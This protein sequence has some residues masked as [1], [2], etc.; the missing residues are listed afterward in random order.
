L[1]FE[2]DGIE[3]RDSL[4][5]KCLWLRASCDNYTENKS[6]IEIDHIVPEGFDYKRH[7]Q[8]PARIEWAIKNWWLTFTKV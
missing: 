2:D 5:G 1:S 4:H 6:I 7:K 3:A 8:N